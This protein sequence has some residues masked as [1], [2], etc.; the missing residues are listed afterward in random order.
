MTCDEETWAKWHA[1]WLAIA[2]DQ[3]LPGASAA[4]LLQLIDAVNA[5][6][7]AGYED[8]GRPQWVVT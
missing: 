3:Q 4:Y 1:G 8:E 2:I 6:Y 5:A 7:A